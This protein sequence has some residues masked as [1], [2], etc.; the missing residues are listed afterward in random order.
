MAPNLS[1]DEIDDLLY[2][3][4]TGE[5]EEL[6]GDLKALAEREGVSVGEVLT[7]ARDESK[8]TCLH[9]ASGNG[10]LGIHFP[11]LLTLPCPSNL[12]THALYLAWPHIHLPVSSNLIYISTSPSSHGIY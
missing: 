10:H 12:T 3:A 9:M 2:L 5:N 7:A 4:R 1:E 8:A 6:E 11:P